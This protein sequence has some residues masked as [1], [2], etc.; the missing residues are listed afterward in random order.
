MA[1]YKFSAL[2]SYDYPFPMSTNQEDELW[3]LTQTLMYT[4]FLS[5]FI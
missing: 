3:L 2:F 4:L 1:D 5:K